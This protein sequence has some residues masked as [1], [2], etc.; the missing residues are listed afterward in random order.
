MLL[1]PFLR[2]RSLYSLPHLSSS[3]SSTAKTARLPI[4]PFPLRHRPL[5][6][7]SAALGFSIPLL[8]PHI[9]TLFDAS[10]SSS[11]SSSPTYTHSRDAQTPLTKDSRS[12]NPAAVKQISLGSILGLGAG[13][14]VSAFSRTLTLLLGVG[15]VIVQV[16][17]GPSRSRTS[18][19]TGEQG[20]MLICLST[21]RGKERLRYN[22]CGEDA[23]IR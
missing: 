20:L 16:W 8:A 17:L 15:I 12:L 9:P 3:F 10:F 19:G 6:L 2:R 4:S 22:S 23:E 1:R 5:L 18:R 14:L 7:T 13:V 21:V 11:S